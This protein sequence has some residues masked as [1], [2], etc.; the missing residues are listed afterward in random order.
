MIIGT[1]VYCLKYKDL[2]GE[3]TIVSVAYEYEKI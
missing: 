1:D 3:K 2:H